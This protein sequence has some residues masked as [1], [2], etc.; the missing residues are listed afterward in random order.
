MRSNHDTRDDG[1]R[2]G[3]FDMDMVDILVDLKAV[4]AVARCYPLL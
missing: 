4:V 3:S 1:R 2:S